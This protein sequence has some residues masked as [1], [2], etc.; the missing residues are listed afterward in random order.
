MDGKALKTLE[1]RQKRLQ[2]RSW[3]D[4]AANSLKLLVAEEGI[5]PPTRGL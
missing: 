5:E 3:V 2:H 4:S 1:K